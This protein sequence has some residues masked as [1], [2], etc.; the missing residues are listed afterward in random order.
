MDTFQVF[1]TVMV[2]GAVGVASIMI[3]GKY[4]N[5]R[6]AARRSNKI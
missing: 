5:A 6:L 3:I 2:V 1:M 4:V